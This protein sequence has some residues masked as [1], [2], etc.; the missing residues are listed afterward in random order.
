MT[1]KQRTRSILALAM[2]IIG[3]MASQ[4][5]L[6]LIDVAMVGEL[7]S[8]A[9][10]ATTLG[11]MTVWLAGAFFMAFGS[12]VQAITARRVGEQDHRG[13]VM[14]LHAALVV[15]L[16][17]VVPWGLLLATKST[18]IFSYLTSDPE[19]MEQGVPY[20]RI[21]LFAVALV[22]ANF[23]FRGYW[24]G[25]GK[26]MVYLRTILTIHVTNVILNWLLIYGHLGFPR[27]EVR[28]AALASAIAVGVGT[29]T[30]VLLAL[31]HSGKHGFGNPLCKAR[32]VMGNV[33]KLSVPSGIQN[34]F[35]SAG[36]VSFVRIAE[37]IGTAEVAATGALINL[38]MVCVLPA[39]GFGLAAATLVG[40]AL[41]EKDPEE[42][43]RWAR[44]TLK[45]AFK[46][47]VVI[48]LVLAVVPKLWLGLLMNDPAAE[49]AAVIP[50]VVLG[51]SQPIDSIGVVL[52]QTLI[53]AGYVRTVTVVV[54]GLQWGLFLPSIFV[55]V[56]YYDGGLL[57]I[58]IAMG[59]WRGI[60]AAV[61]WK[62]FNGGKWTEVEV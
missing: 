40:K 6:N 14:A 3:G 42:A 54:L 5:V 9:L 60:Q 34:I 11:G 15:A 44:A 26:S 36:F 22:S 2:P 27:M 13:A 31:K 46:A 19:V 21:R 57:G 25:L 8:P 24:N 1:N 35:F 32:G 41:G 50:L 62:L 7:G 23:S 53:G 28:G 4:N 16:V 45:I 51:L 17:I 10:A 58:F 30:Y 47:F 20:L 33:L 61:M 52:M 55:Y 18:E 43:F 48:G 37:L 38:A 49:A 56:R 39:I 29:L 59:I 12:G